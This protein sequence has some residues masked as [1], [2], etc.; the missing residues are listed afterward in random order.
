MSAGAVF[1][2]IANDGK[3]REIVCRDNFTGLVLGKPGAS[4]YTSN[5]RT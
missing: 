4:N 5:A 2:L 3:A 1:K